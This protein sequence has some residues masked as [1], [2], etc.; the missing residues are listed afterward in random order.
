MDSGQNHFLIASCCKCTYLVQH[1]SNL[2]AANTA[3]RIRDD[4]IRTELVASVLHLDIGPYM[5]CRIAYGKL[6]VFFCLVDLDHFYFFGVFFFIFF[7]RFYDLLFLIISKDQIHSAV[8]FQ[9]L[10]IC[11]DITSCCHNNGIRIHFFCLME[12]LSGFAV[13][14]IGDCTGIDQINIRPFFKRND[15]ISCFFQKLLHGLYFICIYFAA[16]IVKGNFFT[17]ILPRSFF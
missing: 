1:F 6:L 5:F 9:L 10:C 12:H 8:L 15:L 7:Q 17:H 3:S 2:S 11:L 16:Q 14:D 13:C 4:A